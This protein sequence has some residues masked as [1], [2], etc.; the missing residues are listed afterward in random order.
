MPAIWVQWWHDPAASS[1]FAIA[2]VAGIFAVYQLRSIPRERR[3]RILDEM[4]KA[5]A[6]TAEKRGKLLRDCPMLIQI[7]YDELAS[8]ID[9]QVTTAESKLKLSQNQEANAVAD[10]RLRHLYALQ[11]ECRIWNNAKVGL[12]YLSAA[13]ILQSEFKLRAVLWCVEVLTDPDR[14]TEVGISAELYKTMEQLVGQLNSFAM[15]Y[16]NGSFPPRTL[17]GQL[18][19]SI[20]PTAAALGPLIWARSISGRWGRRLIRLG[21]AAEHY[22]DVTRIHRNSDLIWIGT[23]A[24][25]N[26][27]KV[28]VHPAIAVDLFGEQ[29][30]RMD[31]PGVTRFAPALRLKIRAFYWYIIGKLTLTPNLWAWSYGG[32][33]LMLHGRRENQLAACLRYASANLADASERASLD[34]S[35]SSE[36]LH[37]EMA[38]ATQAGKAAMKRYA[39][40]SA[41][42]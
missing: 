28:V 22:N 3:R 4:T 13:E 19:R 27:R 15:D 7:A 2:I 25:G 14:R 20:A 35:W 42:A 11:R 38:R 24:D 40:D 5:Y 17:F 31:I 26:S 39:G 34:F 41:T 6:A 30:L 12:S 33:R 9:K 8:D 37:A 21:L 1:A 18:H 23:G 36:S 16:E 32:Y 29:V 10:I